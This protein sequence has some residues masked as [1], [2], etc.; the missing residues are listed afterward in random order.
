MKSEKIITKLD[1]TSGVSA[2][3]SDHSR[4]YYGGYYHVCLKISAEVPLAMEWFQNETEHADAVRRLG[5][6]AYFRRKLE[7]MAVPEDEVSSIRQGLL[8]SFTAHMLP[9]L[10]R[11]DFPRRFVLSEYKAAMTKP[12]FLRR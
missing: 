8:D 7:K 6:A 11:Q 4:H 2:I 5:A 10:M 3:V 12:G 1:L 9:Y